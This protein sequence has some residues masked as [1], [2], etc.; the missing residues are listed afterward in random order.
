MKIINI[1]LRVQTAAILKN[2]SLNGLIMRFHLGFR[3]PE[4]SEYLPI[5]FLE[6]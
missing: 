5:E 4:T 2:Y 6:S 1:E 3:V